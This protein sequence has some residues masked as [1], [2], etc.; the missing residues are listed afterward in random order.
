MSNSE[1][2]VDEFLKIYLDAGSLRQVEAKSG[3]SWRQ[4]RNLYHAA[5]Q[6]GRMDPI[7]QG[8]K[9]REERT[10]PTL[11]RDDVANPADLDDPV[12][13]GQVKATR[14]PRLPLPPKGKIQR[15]I[16]TCAQNNT[17]IHEGLWENL[18]A[19]RSHFGN[20][21]ILISRFT[22]I[23]AG[24]GARGDKAQLTGR[25]EGTSGAGELWWDP[26]L[27]PFMSDQRLAL[28]PDLVWCGEMNVL[29]TAVNPL[30]GMDIYTG[31]K[32]GIFPHV[33]IAMRSIASDGEDEPPKFNYTTGALS[34]RNYI[35]KKAG[36]K[37]EFHHCYGGLLVE[38]D[39]KGD[40]WVRQLNADS[41]GTIYDFNVRVENGVVTTGHRPAGITWGDP[42]YADADPQAIHT[43]FAPGGMKDTLKP[44]T[45][46]MG[47]ILDFK[48]RPWQSVR[49][50][51]SRFKLHVEGQ[52]NVEEE[53]RAAGKF[54]DWMHRDWCE[55]YASYG[56]HEDKMLRWIVDEDAR[57][58]PV[59]VE[60]WL[61]LQREV[62]RAIRKGYPVGNPL[63]LGLILVAAF[64]T[65]AR[66]KF[67]D[68]GEGH[69]ICPHASGGIQV[70]LHGH[71]GPR[72]ARGSPAAFA[73]MGRKMNC[74]HFHGAMIVDGVYVA[75]T[76][77]NLS[78][79][80]T[81]GYPSDWSHSQIVTYPN[82]K[83]TIVT[84]RA[85]QWAAGKGNGTP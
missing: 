5:I 2:T 20:T 33:K 48:T 42:H 51:L 56:N 57:K 21:D 12:I 25:G 17:K 70:G 37:A 45:D 60:F 75:G 71:K 40:W 67:L 47:D 36:L 32:S 66:I 83:R 7:P 39:H 35:Q 24:L 23:K 54:L 29:P 9:T 72:G 30:S 69:V 76:L 10:S 65:L 50:P 28:A 73:R 19:L 22:Y 43:A 59:N 63:E 4:V 11:F 18:L 80:W 46:A 62:Y 15:Y 14:T 8:N 34:M 6:E 52:E 61:A 1:I 81:K 74:Q 64:P 58:D 53:V 82:G 55:T 84:F 38:V 16:L 31:Q 79:D 26:R 78:P 44:H 77:Q 68:D 3:L 27:D 13:Q 41:E 49:D 85:N